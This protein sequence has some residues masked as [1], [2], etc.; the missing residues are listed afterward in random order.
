M[1]RAMMDKYP[2]GNPS[3]LRALGFAVGTLANKLGL[4]E[5]LDGFREACP[6]TPEPSLIDQYAPALMAM[7]PSLQNIFDLAMR[8]RSNA[9]MGEHKRQEDIGRRQMEMVE[10]L[11]RAMGDSGPASPLGTCCGKPNCEHTKAA[12]SAGPR[13]DCCGTPGCEHMPQP[14]PA[15]TAR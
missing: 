13:K 7:F 11:R 8:A 5:V 2:D 10:M 4:R 9:K 14:G 3:L 12:P 6:V 1:L 15:A